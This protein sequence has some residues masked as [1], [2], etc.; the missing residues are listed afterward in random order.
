MSNC[1][2]LKSSHSRLDKGEDVLVDNCRHHSVV[3]DSNLHVVKLV[4][5]KKLEPSR[6]F[7]TLA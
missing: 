6:D 7:L 2:E 3:L 5:N 1:G 4:V